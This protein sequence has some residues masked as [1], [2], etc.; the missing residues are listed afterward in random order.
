M[1]KKTTDRAEIALAKLQD[2]IDSA[3]FSWDE[4]E[5]TLLMARSAIKALL[6][7]RAQ[8]IAAAKVIR[9]A[10]PIFMAEVL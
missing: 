8:R 2:L 1:T 4:D 9:E 5:N 10:M 3:S 7:E 6:E